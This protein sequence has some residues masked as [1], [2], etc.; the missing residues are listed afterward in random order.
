MAIYGYIRKEFPTRTV[1]Q[2]A[3]LATYDCTDVYIDTEELT[4]DKELN[5]LLATLGP[6]DTLVIP[7]LA[8]FG[9]KLKTLGEIMAHLWEL[10]VR[11]I[12]LGEEL[13]TRHSPYVYQMYGVVAQTEQACQKKISKQ[14]MERVRAK[15]GVIGR[16]A[17]SQETIEKI[18]TLA[19]Q[20]YSLRQISEV[21]D[22][23]LGSVHKYV[24]EGLRQATET[25]L[26]VA[27]SC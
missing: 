9:K 17:I 7:S 12:S 24:T 3:L 19:H 18:Q 11:L 8:V 26:E 21:C 22:V 4:E 10:S 20:K 6:Q 14:A 16:P 15:G 13:D 5:R 23:S 25:Q 27:S 2:L 1:E